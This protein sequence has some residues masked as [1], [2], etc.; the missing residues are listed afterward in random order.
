MMNLV[1][2]FISSSQAL[3][4]LNIDSPHFRPVPRPIGPLY[5]VS[6]CWAAFES[7]RRP[8]AQAPKASDC[9]SHCQ[10]SSH[11]ITHK[12]VRRAVVA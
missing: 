6:E 8:R 5:M 3:P 11:I 7:R 1:P 10:P 9:D 2:A 4:A 12:N